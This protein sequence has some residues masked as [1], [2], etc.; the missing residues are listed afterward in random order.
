MA[1]VDI[2]VKESCRDSS[3][4]TFGLVGRISEQKGQKEAIL[5][6]MKLPG[7]NIRL[8]LV[9]SDKNQFADQLKQFA[10]ENGILGKV[11]LL[12][13]LVKQIIEY[14]WHFFFPDSIFLKVNCIFLKCSEKHFRDE[15]FI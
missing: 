12:F 11:I 8:I 9:G 15:G 2:I 6:L 3:Y 4:I 7:K 14:Q 13:L 1:S 10:T 5:A